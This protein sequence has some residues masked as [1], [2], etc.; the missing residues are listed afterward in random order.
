MPATIEDL[1]NEELFRSWEGTSA[2]SRIITYNGVD[3]D[4]KLWLQAKEYAVRIS[5]S[6]YNIKDANASRGVIYR[7][8][9]DFIR[10]CS[11][12]ESDEEHDRWWKMTMR[13]VL[14]TMVSTFGFNDYFVRDD[15]DDYV[16]DE[17]EFNLMIDCICPDFCQFP[18]DDT[19]Y[20]YVKSILYDIAKEYL[21]EDF[22]RYN[23]I[24]QQIANEDKTTVTNADEKIIMKELTDEE[25]DDAMRKAI[26]KAMK[27]LRLNRH[28]FCILKVLI[29]HGFAVDFK[30]AALFVEN[31]IGN[32][33]LAQFNHKIDVADLERM[34]IGPFMDEVSKWQKDAGYRTKGVKTY[35]RIA[36]LFEKDLKES[37]L[38]KELK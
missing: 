28:W 9:M 30:S 33:E 8:S 24:D 10:I 18:A 1:R 23:V 32:E 2:F 20:D 16:I 5:Q 6:V 25:K 31:I 15:Y 12:I 17:T 37:G 7:P 35:K 29:I 26:E 22:C 11:E 14:F 21:K 19:L 3:A 38:I 34:H 4:I 27:N 13:A 36:Q